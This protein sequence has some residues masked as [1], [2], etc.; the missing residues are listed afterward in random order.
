MNA[1]GPIGIFDSG[2]GGLVMTKAFRAALPQYDFLYLGDTLHVPYGPR[3]A[4]AILQFTTQAV[5]YLFDKGC[6]LVIIACNTASANALRCIQQEYL[7]INY[8]DRRALGVI[9][10]TIEATIGTGHHRIGLIGTAFTVQSGTYEEEL[11]KLNPAIRLSAKATPLLVPLAE[12]DGIKY[13]KPILQDYLAPLL[14]DK[15]DSLILGCTHYP[16]FKDALKEILPPSVD[17]IAQNEVVPPKLVDYLHRHPEIAQRISTGGKL[18][19]CLTDVT[20]TYT[21]TGADLLGESITFEK[22]VLD[23]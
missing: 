14:D 22:V 17:I 21:R 10:P 5:D 2:L 15:I 23:I 7:P 18:E 8:P 9:V 6:P 13:A 19:A 4:N 3:S 1:Q 11:R 12:N 16:L 20:A